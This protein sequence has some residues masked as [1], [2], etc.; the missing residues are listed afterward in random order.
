MYSSNLLPLLIGRIYL[1]FSV[2]SL[3]CLLNYTQYTM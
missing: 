2:K 3:K 1:F